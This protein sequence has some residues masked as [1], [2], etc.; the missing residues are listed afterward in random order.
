VFIQKEQ[1]DCVYITMREQVGRLII[2]SNHKN[3]PTVY[4]QT[5]LIVNQ[6]KQSESFK[7]V[8][9]HNSLIMDLCCET[10]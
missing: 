8:T 10:V 9:G 2:N 7:V 5:I 4:A 6:T 1:S 3:S